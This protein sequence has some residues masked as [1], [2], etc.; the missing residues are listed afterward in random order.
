M[1]DHYLF[2]TLRDN[3]FAVF[4]LD[5]G[6]LLREDVFKTPPPNILHS[7][8]HTSLFTDCES[9]LVCVFRD[10]TIT[11][12]PIQGSTVK[13]GINWFIPPPDTDTDDAHLRDLY[14]SPIMVDLDNDGQTEM[15]MGQHS[16]LI[17]VDPISTDIYD[18]VI[19]L[20]VSS[21]TTFRF[22]QILIGDIN[23]DRHPELL[24]PDI[25]NKISVYRL[26][27]TISKGSI[28]Y[29]GN[30]S[31]SVKTVSRDD[32]FFPD[33]ET[34][35]RFFFLLFLLMVTG[36]NAGTHMLKRKKKFTRASRDQ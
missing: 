24:I 36:I 6:S 28:L 10:R 19:H 22:S 31:F 12:Y 23:F 21:E 5:K 30:P 34:R 35:I 20:P 16:D 14:L 26:N 17:I 27:S 15:V 29:N 18:N 11:A 2:R 1:V 32:G 7:V 4:D 25:E 13:E 8:H 9:A 3:S 33:F